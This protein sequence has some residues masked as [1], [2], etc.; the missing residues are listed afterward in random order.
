M[1]LFDLPTLFTNCLKMSVKWCKALGTGFIGMY[2]FTKHSYHQS[3]QAIFLDVFIVLFLPFYHC[4]IVLNG[5]LECMFMWI[6]YQPGAYDDSIHSYI[7][8]SPGLHKVIEARIMRN[9]E[10]D[11]ILSGYENP[12]I[13]EPW[14]WCFSFTCAIFKHIFRNWCLKRVPLNHSQ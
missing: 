6:T 14:R 11:T 9:L 5:I 1:Q 7:Y 3:S 13:T 12:Y 4:L 2:T 8:A 10:D